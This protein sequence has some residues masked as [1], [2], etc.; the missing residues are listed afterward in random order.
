MNGEP[1]AAGDVDELAAGDSLVESDPVGVR[2][3]QV[4]DAIAVEVAGKDAPAV[5]L[6]TFA[7]P[8]VVELPG[9]DAALARNL[10]EQIALCRADLNLRDGA[11]RQPLPL[12]QAVLG[13]L[14]EAIAEIGDHLGRFAF[15]DFAPQAKLC[16]ALPG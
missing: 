15:L 4:D 11:G 7:V 13:R 1:E 10:A 16:G 3:E 5:H 14:D 9:V 12:L 6:G 8:V 2:H